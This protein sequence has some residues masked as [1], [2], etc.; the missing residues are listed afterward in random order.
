MTAVI[1]I[2]SERRGENFRLHPEEMRV[3]LSASLQP[4][5]LQCEK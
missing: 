2:L 4:D 5:R 3:A 1:F